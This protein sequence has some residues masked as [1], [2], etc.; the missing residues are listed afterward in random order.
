[1]HS[2]D[3]LAGE[4]RA[5]G[6]HEMAAKA[7]TGYYHDYLSPLDFPEI[8]LDKDLL[9]AGTDEAQKLRLRHHQ[10]AFDATKEESDDWA[11]SEDGQNAF[12]MLHPK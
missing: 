5:A 6:L 4:L 1:M 7:E 2:K 8:E 10:G 3:F 12:R 9:E 11:A